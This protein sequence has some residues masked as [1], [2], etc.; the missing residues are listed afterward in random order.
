MLLKANIY[1][2]WY[3]EQTSYLWSY[4]IKMIVIILMTD[5]VYVEIGVL[6]KSFFC[7]SL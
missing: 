7:K 4:L 5:K 3:N 2:E 6:L 1:Y